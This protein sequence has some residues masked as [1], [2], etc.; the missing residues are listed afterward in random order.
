LNGA[1]LRKKAMFKV[2]VAALYVESPSHDAA[3]V[4]GSD[5]IRSMRLHFLRDVKDTAITEAMTEGFERN[6]KAQMPALKD[7]LAKFNAMVPNLAEG[8]DMVMTY[9]PGKGTMVSVKGA[10]KGVIEGKDFADALFTVW[11]GADPVQENLK[12][13]LLKG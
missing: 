6:S 10:E 8:D 5:Q 9:V 2:Y 13:D 12:A 1:G 3:A 4:T 7:R 11:L